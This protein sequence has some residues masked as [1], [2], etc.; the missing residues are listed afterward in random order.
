MRRREREV[1]PL[2]LLAAVQSRQEKWL[3][4]WLLYST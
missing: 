1:K 3:N 4:R 2:Q